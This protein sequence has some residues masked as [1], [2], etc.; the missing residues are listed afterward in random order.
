MTLC[1][2][3]DSNIKNLRIDSILIL[4]TTGE[5][6]T[7]SWDEEYI[8]QNENGFDAICSKIYFDN[9]PADG[10]IKDLIG[11]EIRNIGIN[12]TSPADIHLTIRDMIFTDTDG[13][14]TPAQTLPY[15][16][17]ATYGV[18]SDP[19]N[20]SVKNKKHRRLFETETI[21][22]CTEHFISTRKIT[23][24]DKTFLP[25]DEHTA[26]AL[27]EEIL[28]TDESYKKQQG[29]TDDDDID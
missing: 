12:T 24:N 1:I 4:L 15:H 19:E 17:D 20:H 7:M 29:W 10:Q 18:K 5:N 6:V 25:V 3:V 9:E 28:Q 16:Y 13:Q 27:L 8:T 22:N 14:Y 2:S 23:I 11:M 26:Y 21:K